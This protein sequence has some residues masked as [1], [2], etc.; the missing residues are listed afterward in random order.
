MRCAYAGQSID[1]LND[2][3]KTQYSSSMNYPAKKISLCPV[4]GQTL[5]ASAVSLR[6]W[7]SGKRKVQGES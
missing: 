6:R 3:E 2:P 4:G 5:L 1:Q 7:R